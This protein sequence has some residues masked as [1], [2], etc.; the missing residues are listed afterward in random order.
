MPWWMTSRPSSVTMKPW[1]RDR[2]RP[3]RALSTLATSRLACAKAAPVEK[4]GR[5]YLKF[6]RGLSR[7]LA[8]PAEDMNAEFVRNGLSPR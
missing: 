6:L 8:A 7:M 3:H 4:R 5:R 1:S 2:N